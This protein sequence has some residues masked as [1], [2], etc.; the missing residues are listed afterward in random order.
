[1]ICFYTDRVRYEN[2]PLKEG[3]VDVESEVLVIVCVASKQERAGMCVERIG[4][5][6]NKSNYFN[7]CNVLCTM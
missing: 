1:M 2:S 7:V 5:K 3:I 4:W 6:P